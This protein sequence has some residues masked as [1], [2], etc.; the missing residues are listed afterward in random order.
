[1]TIDFFLNRHL[2]PEEIITL[3]YVVSILRVRHSTQ[4]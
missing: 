2:L 1:M 4:F 3:N